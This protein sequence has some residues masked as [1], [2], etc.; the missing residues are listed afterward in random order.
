[1]EGKRIKIYPNQKQ[2]M[3]SEVRTLLRSRN[4]AFKSGNREQYSMARAV[5][6]RGIKVAE[7]ADKRKVEDH[8]ANNNLGLVWQ[9][10]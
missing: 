3:T 10:L 7:V 8:L 4:S 1:M 9:V 6:Q 5:L 2:W